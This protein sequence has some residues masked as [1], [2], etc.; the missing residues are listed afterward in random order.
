MWMARHH[1]I[2][3]DVA[4]NAVITVTVSVMMIVASV[5]LRGWGC[6]WVWGAN[7]KRAGMPT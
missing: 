1:A 4:R 6:R 5:R 3:M 7:G 2:M